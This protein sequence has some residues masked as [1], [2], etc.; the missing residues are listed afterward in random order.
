M[1]RSAIAFISTGNFLMVGLSHFLKPSIILSNDR[2][3]PRGLALSL[4]MDIIW[5]IATQAA[6]IDSEPFLQP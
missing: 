4:I 6:V 5:Q 1:H 2:S 3:F